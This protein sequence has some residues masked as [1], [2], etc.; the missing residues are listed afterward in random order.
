MQNKI[1]KGMKSKWLI[2][3]LTSLLLIMSLPNVDAQVVYHP[4]FLPAADN[5]V[6]FNT[7]CQALC[8]EEFLCKGSI[9]T[10]G[11]NKVFT[12][13]EFSVFGSPLY[14]SFNIN[15]NGSGFPRFA[16]VDRQ[17]NLKPIASSTF[18]KGYLHLSLDTISQ[19][20]I[21]S[22]PNDRHL[23][24]LVFY[25]VD[26]EHKDTHITSIDQLFPGSEIC[27]PMNG[28]LFFVLQA[29]HQEPQSIPEIESYDPEPVLGPISPNQ[30]YIRTRT[31]RSESGDTY[32]ERKDFFDGLGRPVQ[33]VQTRITPTY[34]DLAT[35]QQYDVYGRESRSW[36]PVYIS[37]NNGSYVRPDSIISKVKRCYD[38]DSQTY[39]FPVYE[40]SPLNFICKQ[41]GAG[42]DWHR[43]RKGVTY[44][45]FTNLSDIDS[46]TCIEYATTESSVSDTVLIIN[47]IGTYS[48]NELTVARVEDEDGNVSFEFKN[49]QGQRI[50]TRCCVNNGNIRTF[51]DT[52]YIYDTFNLKAVLPPLASDAMK[53]GTTWSNMGNDFIRDYAYLYKY[54]NRNRCIAKRIPGVQWIYYVYDKADRL[55]LSQNGEQR[56]RNEWLFS[57][58]DIFGRV[59]LT[60]I[61]TDDHTPAI[62]SLADSIV[63]A[64]WYPGH[65]DELMGYIITG[66]TLASPIVM[67]ANYYDHYDFRALGGFSNAGL[68]Y[69]SSG[70]DAGYLKRYGDDTSQSKYKHKGLLTGVA[71]SVLA[72]DSSVSNAYLYNTMY[73]DKQKRLI[74]LKETNYLG[75]IE[76]RYTAYNFVGQPVQ[77]THTHTAEGKKE[78]KEVLTYTYDHAGR[79]LATT[80]KLN[81]GVEVTLVSNEYDELGRLKSNSYNGQS[82]FKTNYTYNIRSWIKTTSNSLFTQTLY[83][84][85]HRSSGTNNPSYNGSISGMDWKVAN[86]KNRGYNISYDNLS[87]LTGA[88]YLEGN[89]VSDKFNTSYCYDKHGNMLSLSRHGNVGTSTYGIVD[90]L[91]LGYN[92]NQLVSV[93]DKGTNPSLSMS[94]DFKDGSHSAVEYSYD[95]NGNMVKDLNKGISRIEYNFLNLPQQISFSGAN[96]PVNEYVYSA[97][98]KKLSVIHRSSTVKR[99]DY[100]GNM[101]Y[102]N[103]SLKRILIDGGYIENGVYHFYLQDHLGNN[104]VVAKSDGT[105]I[106]TNHYYPYGMYFAEGSFADKQ[107]YKYNG[108]EL[109][110]ENGLDIYDYDARQMEATL[111]RFTSVDPMAE[112]YYSVSPYAYCGNN[113]VMLVDV[114]G[115][116]WGIVLNA[117][118]TMTVTLAVNLR[119]SSD[120]NLTS[121]QIGEIKTA[122]SMQLN[123]TFQDVS[124]GRISASMSFDGGKDPNRLT[125]TI[126]L[127]GDNDI[128]GLGFTY[129]GDVQLNVSNI[130]E[131]TELGET[132]VHELFHTLNLQDL[133][134]TPHISD[135]KLIKTD[136]GYVTTSATANNIH[137]NIM[138]YG[139]TKI[140]GKSYKEI[141]NS[142]SGMN[143]ITKG[144]L[145]FLIKSIMMQMKGYG[146]RPIRKENETT[147]EYNQ[148]YIE[149][150]NNYWNNP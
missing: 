47:K 18:S 75:G 58:P 122:I 60:G 149:Y 68:S 61:C 121:S 41:Y 4:E 37:G 135:T 84:N 73:Y 10:S 64:E 22:T 109:D 17:F 97:G 72:S 23:L 5:A 1:K 131:M 136:N 55:I 96:N 12:E 92:G 63:R 39:N 146:Q 40:D 45:D 148:R 78:Q 66:I 101:I 104:R 107:P 133:T 16:V 82:N 108:K 125:P 112:K 50:L 79:L 11:I 24:A 134:D 35:M 124:G 6:Y 145:S 43:K 140:D 126:T 67:T 42:E 103:G 106:Q 29:T 115:K 100:V 94:M 113:P 123:N 46:L 132:G 150:F 7:E 44:S 91:T 26:A 15:Y 80:H 83:Y 102:E 77:I 70:I 99:T 142:R 71:I 93:E 98:G 74:Q 130:S 119:T 110:T 14:I 36:L 137:K 85:D 138:N 54:D 139:S 86:D 81:N 51:Y 143:Q 56:K 8:W 87:R 59:V 88:D 19:V 120:L 95:G 20:P 48:A 117:N 128:M 13:M 69:T 33:S 147:E 49:K 9:S 65:S 57:I 90:D 3:I 76:A 141:Y 2:H 52:Y 21:P 27:M 32:L 114:N 53:T 31:M 30:N 144:Q 28:D 116:E 105:V 127:N 38:G 111:G 62:D 89:V 25:V 129:Y 118:G 34:G